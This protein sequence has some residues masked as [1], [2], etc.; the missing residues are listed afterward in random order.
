MKC[1]L[2]L[3]VTSAIEA[4]HQDVGFEILRI[5]P[6]RVNRR[7]LPDILVWLT[8]RSVSFGYTGIHIY[9]PEELK[10][11]QVGYP[12]GPGGNSVVNDAAGSWQRNWIVIGCKA[13]CGDPI[14]VDVSVED[15]PVYTAIHGEGSWTPNLIA[16]NI[17]GF[18]KALKSV[19]T[20]ASDRATALLFGQRSD[21]SNNLPHLLIGHLFHCGH[22]AFA[23]F[24]Y[25]KQFPI[26]IV[27][28][29][30]F[31]QMGRFR[32]KR[33]TRRAIARP[34]ITMAKSTVSLI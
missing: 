27:Y 10:E 14:F 5:R 2:A 30:V 25:Q 16:D 26:R 8:Y 24:Q 9:Q 29:I 34:C 18:S 4:P 6:L 33:R 22:F 17:E 28:H 21:I 23:L 32:V 12:I 19:A 11:A 7:K 31:R 15:C 13:L 3:R 1:E 20:I